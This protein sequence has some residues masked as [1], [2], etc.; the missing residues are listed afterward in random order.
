MN[1]VLHGDWG[2]FFY[3]LIILMIL[4]MS[5]GLF[6]SSIARSTIFIQSVGIGILL[7]TLFVGPA[8][9]PVAMV[10]SIDVIK[11][12]GYLLPLKYPISTMIE[13]LTGGIDNSIVNINNS[14]IWNPNFSY[15]V[16]D[17]YFNPLDS[18][19]SKNPVLLIFDYKD[20]ILNL[21]LPYFFTII[22]LYLTAS[23]FV[24]SNR[25]KVSFEWRIITNTIKKIKEN[26]ENIKQ[27]KKFNNIND[28]HSEYILEIN[29]I[30]KTFN[31]NKKN[32]VKASKNISFNVRRGHNLAILGGNGAGKTILTEMIIGI[33]KP[34]S[35]T[36]KYNYIFNKSYQE[37]IGIQFQ[38]SSY[39]IGIKCRD[40]VNFFIEI[41]N[42][43]F[44]KN[45][46]E[47]LIKEFGL[48]EFYNKNASSLSGGQQQRLNLLLSVLHKPSLLFLDELSTGLDIKIRNNIKE[49]IKKYAIENDITIVIVSHDMSEVQYLCEDIVTIKDG[50]IIDKNT[51]KSIL[52]KHS[53]LEEYISSHL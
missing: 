14:S 39:P 48:I 23:T 42:L 43:R 40:I 13:S 16:Y 1:I 51:I 35:G 36:F 10:G 27:E 4:T 5:I 20:K 8:C 41:F 34:D 3:S 18:N 53:N 21:V 2:S 47:K 12:F 33:N 26:K 50:E 24:W 25:S 6:I 31:K 37:K 15:S 7:I 22:F 11:Y 46:L 17:V 28:I 9:L 44:K 45:E 30:N 29:N 49:F 52:E 38:D 19:G 32:E